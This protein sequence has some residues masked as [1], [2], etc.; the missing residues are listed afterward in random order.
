MLNIQEQYSL[1]NLTTF[2][3]GGAADYFVSV[4]SLEEL[5]EA[6][7]YAEEKSLPI[8]IMG[9]GSNMLVSDAGFRGVVI[10]VNIKGVEF[11]ENE[12]TVEVKAQAG[13]IWDEVVALAVFRELWGIENLSNIPGK[14]GGFPVQNVGAYGQEAAL[15]IKSVEVYDLADSEVK[16]FSNEDC[17]FEY[18]QSN[19]N[20]I[21]K[22]KFVILSVT[23]ALS[24]Q[25]KPNLSYVDLQKYFQ[26]NSNPSLAEIR[27]AI[28][29]IRKNKFPDLSELGCAGSFFKNLILTPGQYL[30]LKETITKNFSPEVVA[31]LEEIKYRFVQIKSIKIPAAFLIDICGLKGQQLGGAKLW[32]KQPLVIVNTGTA[33]ATDV[34]GL[35]ERVCKTVFEKTGMSLD[36]EPEFI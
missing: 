8:L 16:T 20:T 11:T 12:Q 21:W 6:L 32:E 31:R 23:M 3:I 15:V 19:F 7:K 35:Y 2:R 29:E 27:Q 17:G 36:H 1:S 14:V 28:I 22:N 24:K 25:P 30:E 4:S 26:N 10:D 33:T 34:L 18:R 9:S 13:E 5:K